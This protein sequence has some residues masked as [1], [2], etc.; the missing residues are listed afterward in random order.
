M[1]SPAPEQPERRRWSA[2]QNE[3]FGQLVAL[4]LQEGFSE[5]T[6]EAAANRLHCSKSTIYSLASSREQLVRTAVVF[7]FKGAAE[8]VEQSLRGTTDPRDRIA[9]YLRAVGNE[10]RPASA[11]FID[12]VASFPPAREIYERN[13][14][15]AA[16]RV[17]ELISEGVDTGSFREVPAAFI[18][19]AVSS[20]M[21]SI[22]QRQI[23][24]GTGLSDAEAYEELATLIV[25][26]I[27][28]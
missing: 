10:L 14:Q 26:G 3:L 5:T 17:R 4:F 19:E 28:V 9:A 13:T 6:L 12:D 18:A 2:R 8:R 25:H 24:Q 11:A 27:R 16:A 21:V 7:F 23:S 20:V 15:I 22:Q 1:L